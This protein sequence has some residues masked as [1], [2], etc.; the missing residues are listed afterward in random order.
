MT[1]LE[2][3][4]APSPR[5]LRTDLLVALAFAVGI[6]LSSVLYRIA[7]I[8]EEP[9]PGWAALPYAMGISLPLI[10][11]RRFPSVTALVVATTFLVGGSFLVPEV[12][13]GN[14]ALFLAFYSVGAWDANRTRAHIVRLVITAAMIIWLFAYIYIGAVSGEQD[15]TG[16]PFSPYVAFALIQVI[17]NLLYFGGAYYYGERAWASALE[18][19]TLAERTAELQFERERLAEQAVALDRVRIARELHDSVAHHVSVMGVQAGAAR[20]TLASDPEAASQAL[21]HVE[22]T[23]RSAIDE[24][25][26]LLTTLRDAGVAVDTSPASTIG[27]T[28]LP[29]LVQASQDAGLPTD[30]EIVGDPRPLPPALSLNVYRIAQEALTNARKHAGP[31]AAAEVRLR[32]LPDA[33]ELEV[34][35]TGTTRSLRAPGGL[36]QLGMRERV[37]T[38]GGSLEIGPRS[39]GGY[40]VRARLPLVGA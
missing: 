22:D 13:V 30:L 2:R 14:I 23:A 18:R 33:V 3:R 1:A 36:G 26:G 25:R 10:W 24:L 16:G 27:V 4:P 37:A 9:A 12:L 20:S 8:F 6:M 31:D 11:R 7:G 40:L 19:Q 39:R 29:A 28:A 17:T 34:A 35:N 21:R 5:E 15:T 32:Y 38:A